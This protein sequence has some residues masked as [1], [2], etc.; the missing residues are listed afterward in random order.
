MKKTLKTSINWTILK[1]HTVVNKQNHQIPLK[2]RS[3]NQE[4]KKGDVLKG[5]Y[6]EKAVG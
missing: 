5:I 3:S 6:Q 4:N 1:D 2:I